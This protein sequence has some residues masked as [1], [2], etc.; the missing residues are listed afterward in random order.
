MY[1]FYFKD[2]LFYRFVEPFNKRPNEFN[3]ELFLK[4]I[5]DSKPKKVV[6]VHKSQILK[7]D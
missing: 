4:E 1:Q 6:K 7:K 3:Y 2:N 5:E